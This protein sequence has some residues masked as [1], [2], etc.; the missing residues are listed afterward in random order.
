MEAYIDAG[1]AS[2]RNDYVTAADVESASDTWD[3]R[4]LAHEIDTQWG[5]MPWGGAYS[6]SKT[7]YG[8][9]DYDFY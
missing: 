3:A 5:D 8:P 6:D 2:S 9:G 7:Y 1:V 4:G